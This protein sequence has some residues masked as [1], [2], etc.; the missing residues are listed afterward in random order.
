MLVDIKKFKMG[1]LGFK[2]ILNGR[3]IRNIVQ[4]AKQILS[5]V[6]VEVESKKVKTL[7]YDRGAGIEKATGSRKYDVV[8]ISPEIV[9]KALST[10]PHQ[11]NMYD[12][13]GDLAVELGGNNNYFN[14]GSC[15]ITYFDYRTGKHRSPTTSDLESFTRV[16]DALPNIHMVSTAM[17]A[18]EVNPKIQ[19]VYRLYTVLK[20]SSKP[21]VTGTFTD[22]SNNFSLMKNLLVAVRGS[23]EELKKKP[24]AIFDC[25][26]SP[27]LKWPKI[28]SEDLIRCGEAGIPAEFISMPQPG[29]P[30]SPF[31]LYDCLVQHTAE[32]LS[33]IVISQL[34]NPGAPLIYGGSPTMV[35]TSGT[36]LLGDMGVAKIDTAYA[37]IAKYFS[38]PCQAYL[39]MSDS[40]TI[41][42]Q[43]GFEKAS[44]VLAG[45][46][47]GINNISGPGMSIGESCQSIEQLVL[48]NEV[49]G[50]M[51]YFVKGVE[52][53][54]IDSVEEIKSVA[55]TGMGSD[56]NIKFLRQE[57][58]PRELA[59][60]ENL[61]NWRNNGKETMLGAA[62]RKAEEILAE[63]EPA[64]SSDLQ[65][66]L[67]SCMERLE[68]DYGIAS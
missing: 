32:T 21:V 22:E 10:V 49:C 60:Q 34:A 40:K 58:Y 44:T 3:A 43:S 36:A 8:F 55:E 12:R 5:E 27:S 35:S 38:M 16:A 31:T 19:D 63:Y 11:I 57:V 54:P 45:V 39:G 48:D 25:C 13:N 56:E 51:L 52:K 9:D 7:L 17:N 29:L 59:N 28:W 64:L 47:A 1:Q 53:K 15:A 67:D 65:K 46:L 62:H 33:G 14:P 4:D 18:S 20:N 6:G 24:L 66:N 2:G 61:A 23:E 30:R 50:R 42:F 68:A 26:P 41:D 37:Q